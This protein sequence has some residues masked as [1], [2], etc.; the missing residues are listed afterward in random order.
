[1]ILRTS[2][3]RPRQ[4]A[5]LCQ[6]LTALFLALSPLLVHAQIRVDT[7]YN[8]LSAQLGGALP[9][10]AGV[11]VTQVEATSGGNRPSNT[12]AGT[13]TF[14]GKT[15]T[16]RSPAS[17]A[18]GHAIAVGNNYYGNGIALAP[19][20]TTIDSYEA[21]DWLGVNP[22]VNSNVLQYNTSNNPLV[23]LNGSRIVNH[24]WIYTGET[25]SQALELLERNDWLI[26]T[27]DIIQVAGTN[28]GTGSTNQ[29]LFSY[30]ANTI[31]VGL[32][33]LNHGIGTPTVLTPSGSGGHQVYGRQGT[34][35]HPRPDLVAPESATSFAT[36]IVGSAAALL[37]QASKD[38]PTWS[39]TT[40]VSPRIPTQTIRAA[41]TSEV[42][43]AALLAGAD[44][45]YYNTD[46]VRLLDYRATVGTQSA[47]GLDTRVGAG[48]LNVRNSYNILVGTQ[49]LGATAGNGTAISDAGFDYDAAFGGDAGTNNVAKYQFTG[50]W[51]GQNFAASLVWNANIEI[52]DIF[53]GGL[54]TAANIH[55]F[56]LKLWDIS[57]PAA[58]VLV[59]QSISDRENTENI[60]TTL[61]AGKNYQLEV[62]STDLVN[63]DYGLAWNGISNQLW[64]G[65]GGNNTWNV[66]SAATW[67]RG[68][69][70]AA[71]F[72]D[73]DQVVFNDSAANTTVNIGS[74][75]APAII[76]VDNSAKNYIF[77]G[78]GSITGGALIKKG[79]GSLTLN[80]TN[81]YSGDT[82]LQA[83]SIRAGVAN[84]LS[85][86]SAIDL[87]AGTTLDLL[88]NANTVKHLTGTGTVQAAG[89]ALGL[90]PNASA[91]FAGTL[92]NPTVLNKTLSGTQDFTGNVQW[93]ATNINVQGGLLRFNLSNASTVSL[94]AGTNVAVQAGATLELAGTKSAF[95]NGT[96]NAPVVT[97]AAN[98]AVSVTGTNQIV[99]ALT[100]PTSGPLP[101]GS[102]LGATTIATGANLTAARIRQTS[103]T[104]NGTGRA[105][106]ASN[107]GD[108]G[109]SVVNT[110]T[111]AGGATPTATLDLKDNDLILDYTGS[112]GT[113]LSTLTA[114]IK[115]ARNG[116]DISDQANW[117]GAGL[118][119][120][121]IRSLNLTFGSD[122]YNLGVVDNA[123]FSEL[124]ISSSFTTF[125]GV[126][127]DL[128]SLLVKYTL[129]GDANLDGFVT[130]D[131]YTFWVNGYLSN[132]TRGGWLYGDFDY[133]GSVTTNDYTLWVNSYLAG[134]G[135]LTAS[136][137]IPP[138][139]EPTTWVALLSV[140]AWALSVGTKKRKAKL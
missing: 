97:N 68:T 17:T 23:S 61:V 99:G 118:T 57:T 66:A 1:M 2:C 37:I 110:L 78:T 11:A 86:N 6:A 89:A 56:N 114:Q 38:H 104:I 92:V 138:I 42:I 129:N 87:A 111:L 30:G 124:G 90:A 137:S 69:N 62:S 47:N 91:T 88:G 134:G 55:N 94:T 45:T 98:A 29:A 140:G 135:Q 18:S 12:T 120:S 105:T 44:R 28:N 139:P 85:P 117:T 9:T 93:Q 40:Y 116:I 76:T 70:T 3:R 75:V 95:T 115:A 79:T 49:Q 31:S 84:A 60:F 59:A 71:T 101:F 22:G 8:A 126:P 131:D 39:T 132:G 102:A 128:S 83:G 125:S 53:F 123:A 74:A 63:W 51:T 127:V 20:I 52:G 72:L 73:H 43:R 15:F 24:S 108:S 64:N 10:G 81:S 36:P 136:L 96:I 19:G 7:G 54:E 119:S 65:T 130:A 109:V 13:G 107:G 100:G 34:Y 106:I 41:D 80:N 103:L 133:S 26:A 121:T 35:Q 5:A 14:A 112:V 48:Q 27:D 122:R 58:P 25:T 77:A 50:G 33:N 16:F 46:G 21:G 67:Q 82:L 4:R 113:L 32:S